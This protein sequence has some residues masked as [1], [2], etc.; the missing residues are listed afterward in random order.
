MKNILRKTHKLIVWYSIIFTPIT[1]LAAWLTDNGGKVPENGLANVINELGFFWILSLAYLILALVFY[2]DYR[3][4]LLA[5]L[6]GFKEGD[7]REHLV[8]AN[9]SRA[10]FLLM[11]AL[12]IVLLVMSLTHVHLI[13]DPSNPNPNEHGLLSISMAFSSKQLDIYSLTPAPVKSPPPGS[14][15]FKS[16]LI[17]PNMSLILLLLILVQVG[18]FK[19]L[20]GRRY[21]GLEL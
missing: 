9:A 12:Q 20:S 17:P 15:E 10:T 14:W 2:K 16:Y 13:Y 1:V 3:E 8:T 18:S 6:A 5:R 4:N 7:E 21:E 11:L 19:L